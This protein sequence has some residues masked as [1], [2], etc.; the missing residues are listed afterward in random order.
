MLTDQQFSELHSRYVSSGLSI[1]SFCMNEEICE[2]K[3]YYRKKKMKRFLP[4]TVS[5]DFVPLVIQGSSGCSIRSGHANNRISD[6]GFE[7]CYPN[8]TRLKFSPEG[9][10]LGLLRSLLSLQD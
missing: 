2:S 7:I 6:S 10:D 5:P 3:F 8:G 9:L 4:G 1:R